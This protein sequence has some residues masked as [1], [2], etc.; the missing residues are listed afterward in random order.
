MVDRARGECRG[1]RT[2]R[3]RR[4]VDVPSHEGVSRWVAQDRAVRPG[5]RRSDHSVEKDEIRCSR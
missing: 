5:T 2:P 1:E 4:T 3:R